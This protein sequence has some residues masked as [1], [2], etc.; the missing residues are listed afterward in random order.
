M[1]GPGEVGPR[2][3]VVQ[4]GLNVEAAPSPGLVKSHALCF[5][6]LLSSP[7]FTRPLGNENREGERDRDLE[8]FT[9]ISLTDKRSD[10]PRNDRVSRGANRMSVLVRGRVTDV[11]RVHAVYFVNGYAISG[12][13]IP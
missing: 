9:A 2:G 5:A 6:S 4:L 11:D 7:L 10:Y 13:P 8:R 3:T 12:R 1:S